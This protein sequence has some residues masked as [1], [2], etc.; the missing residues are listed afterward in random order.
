MVGP[1]GVGISYFDTG[2]LKTQLANNEFLRAVSVRQARIA[3]APSLGFFFA[4][5]EPLD[6]SLAPNTLA[7]QGLFWAKEKP[8]KLC[9]FRSHYDPSN[10]GSRP[11]LASSSCMTQLV[12]STGD[13]SKWSSA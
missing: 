11:S 12:K 3:S 1:D 7:T 13:F 10:L 6:T 5:P 9:S 4:F 8:R 2:R